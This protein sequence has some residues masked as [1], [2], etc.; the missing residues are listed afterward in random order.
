MQLLKI[1]MGAGKAHNPIFNGG[2]TAH[3]DKLRESEYLERPAPRKVRTGHGQYPA[4]LSCL[5]AN[6]HTHLHSLVSSDSPHSVSHPVFHKS[7]PMALW[8]K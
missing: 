8:C 6:S 7:G 1:R 2:K 3:M 5:R 4:V